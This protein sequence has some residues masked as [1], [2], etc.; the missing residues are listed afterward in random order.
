LF[1]KIEGAKVPLFRLN[2]DTALTAI[3]HQGELFL[4]VSLAVARRGASG[5]GRCEATRCRT[6][7]G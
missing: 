6:R 1:G 4:F 3:M 7:L 2:S 5:S